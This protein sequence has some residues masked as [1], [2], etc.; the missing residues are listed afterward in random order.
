[1]I[2]GIRY[3]EVAA[4]VRTTLEHLRASAQT[5]GIVY[6]VLKSVWPKTIVAFMPVLIVPV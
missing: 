3:V 6:L 4:A 2:A 5:S 1:M